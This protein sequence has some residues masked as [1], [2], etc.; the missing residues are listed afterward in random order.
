MLKRIGTTLKRIRRLRAKKIMVSAALW[1]LLALCSIWLHDAA[2]EAK[3]EESYTLVATIKK[4]DELKKQSPVR[5]SG[6]EVG[7]ISDMLLRHDFSVDVVMKIDREIRIPDDSVVAIYTDGL[8]GGKYVAILPGGSTD[9]MKNGDSFE[10]AQNSINIS[11]IIET[12]ISSFKKTLD[13][14]KEKENVPPK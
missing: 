7:R 8:L 6:I 11:E 3:S 14:A 1:C 13:A 5:L 4:T 9:Y 2:K 10:Y 12:G